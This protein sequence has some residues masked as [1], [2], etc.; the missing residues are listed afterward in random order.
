MAE[1]LLEIKDLAVVFHTIA[2][3][4]QAVNGVN[5]HLDKGEV[6]A[7]LGESG[8]GKS[9]TASAVLNLIDMPPGEITAGE[10]RF[11]GENLFDMPPARRRDING[12]NIAM[13]FL[14]IHI[15]STLTRGEPLDELN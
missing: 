14:H 5:L 1:H 10:I 13:I 7:I 9:V 6:L 2:G 8:S 11:K 15:F 3:Q 12:K 4:V